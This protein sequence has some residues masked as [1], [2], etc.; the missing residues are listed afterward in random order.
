MGFL[1]KKDNGKVLMFYSKPSYGY[2]RRNGECIS[3]D[4]YTEWEN[5]FL[6]DDMEWVGN[7][8][9]DASAS[10]ENAKGLEVDSF[11]ADCVLQGRKLKQNEL[12]EFTSL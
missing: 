6:V 1:L 5:D 10:N 4:E 3:A 9:Y 11:V 2:Y 7:V 8:W 12:I